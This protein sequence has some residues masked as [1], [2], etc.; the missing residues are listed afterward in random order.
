MKPE[1][2][3]T[4]LGSDP[5]RYEYNPGEHSGQTGIFVTNKYVGTTTHLSEEA[6]A[7]N[8]LIT[9]ITAT[10]QGRNVENITRVTGFL[11]KT[12]GWNKGKIGELKERHKNDIG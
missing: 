6:I 5:D 11:S 9:I 1:E 10:Y 12:S 7:E 8:D 4:Y 2:L 3:L